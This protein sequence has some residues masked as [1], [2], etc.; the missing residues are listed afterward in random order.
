MAHYILPVFLPFYDALKTIELLTISDTLEPCVL[1]L[2]SDTLF[3]TELLQ[4]S[5]TLPSFGYNHWMRYTTPFC[6]T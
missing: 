1:L 4:N 6:Y 5:D 2:I 3:F